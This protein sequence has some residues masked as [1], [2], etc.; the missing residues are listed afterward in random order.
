MASSNTTTTKAAASASTSASAS[1]SELKRSM[2]RRNSSSL[3]TVLDRFNEPNVV[4]WKH[5]RFVVMDSPSDSNIKK[6]VK[7]IQKH[8]TTDVVRACELHYNEEAMTDIGINV[9][10][11]EFTDG[12]PPPQTVVEK[13]LDLVI[14][15]F[16]GLRPL[17]KN[18]ANENN[19]NRSNSQACIAVHCVAGLG[20]APMLVAIALIEA[21][22]DH[23][24]AVQFIR[25]QRRGAFNDKQIRFL[26]DYKPTRRES[27]GACCIV[28]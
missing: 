2:S 17:R 26:E 21:G 28:Q 1:A 5:M 20:R 15:R 4:V 18:P 19:K 27:L 22:F 13:W 3:Q 11:L 24:D 14:D 12:G 10:D 9:H 6:Y 8:G 23:I 7:A 25:R 16:G